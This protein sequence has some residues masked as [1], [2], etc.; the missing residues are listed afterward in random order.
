V[1]GALWPRQLAVLHLWIVA[2][3]L[4][5]AGIGSIVWVVDMNVSQGYEGAQRRQDDVRVCG[6]GG[7]PAVPILESVHVDC[8]LPMSRLTLLEAL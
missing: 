7:A 8:D 4:L 6:T 5:C 1:G 2:L 3:V